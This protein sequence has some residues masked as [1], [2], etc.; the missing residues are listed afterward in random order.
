[1]VRKQLHGH[2]MHL[3]NGQIDAED[4][5]IEYILIEIFDSI[6]FELTNITFTFTF[7]SID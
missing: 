7:I 6:N 1:M 5:S 4:V 3:S 2:G